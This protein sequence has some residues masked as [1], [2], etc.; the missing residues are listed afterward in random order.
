MSLTFSTL[1][2]VFQMFKMTFYKINKYFYVLT[3]AKIIISSRYLCR[4]RL[5]L[6]FSWFKAEK[7]KMSLTLS[8]PFNV[9]Q[10]LK[11]TFYKVDKYFYVLT[12][13]KIIISSRYL[14]CKD[15]FYTFLG[16]KQRKAKCL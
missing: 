10:M 16:L 3:L 2:N 4:I 1:F 7:S 12:L 6:Y 5:F 8:T 14:C 15:Y 9:F 13:A 11:M